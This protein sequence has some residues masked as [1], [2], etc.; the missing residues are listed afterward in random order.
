[1][2]FIESSI[3]ANKEIVN[4]LNSKRDD[5]FTKLDRGAGGDI[6][7]VVD[8]EAEKV[9]IKHL[10]R[11]GKIFSEEC[12]EYGEGEDMIIIDPIDGSENLIS[13]LPYFGTSVSR[14]VDGKVTDAVIVNLANQDIFVKNSNSFR[15]GKLYNSEFSDVI[16]NNYATIGIY[17]RVYASLKFACELNK[18]DIKYRSPGALALSLAY[19]HEVEFVI[20]EGKI[21]EFDVSA[22][23]YMCE[24]LRVYGEDDFLIVSKNERIFEM[25]L[26]IKKG[27]R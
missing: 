6:S 12:G 21:R 5:L 25:L 20:F 1:M 23:L 8:I 18:L 17:E 13:N 14:V 15:K 26:D 10:S 11:F 22:G 4:I 19:A 9:F 24:D 7:R 27:I 2:N 16:I 3:L